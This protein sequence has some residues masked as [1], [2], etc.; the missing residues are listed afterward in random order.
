MP[1]F[2]G[3]NLPPIPASDMQGMQALF[4]ILAD[5]AAAQKRFE[6][7]RTVIAELDKAAAV[8]KE[9][10]QAAIAAHA[11]NKP[12][13]EAAQAQLVEAKAATL[14]HAE[15]RQRLFEW[16]REVKRREDL[17]GGRERAHEQHLVNSIA[18]LNEHERAVGQREQKLLER[19]ATLEA[20]ERALA[21]AK[22]EHDARVDK[23]KAAVG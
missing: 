17:V 15:T 1:A 23:L 5:P 16:E 21:F 12:A 20:N 14:R 22:K 8:A 11:A 6:E 19:E 9:S 4:V 2:G 10:E 18:Q 7:L 3:V 13:L